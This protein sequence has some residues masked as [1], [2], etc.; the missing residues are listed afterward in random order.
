MDRNRAALR[1]AMWRGLM[2]TPLLFLGVFFFYPLAAILF[3]SLL[4]DGTLDLSGFLRVAQSAYYRDTLWFTTWQAA[5]STSLTLGLALPAAYVF[6]RYT[7][8]GRSFLL[9]L[10]TLAFVLPTVVV[11]AGFSALVGPRGLVN[12]FLMRVFSLSAPPIQLQHT[13]TLI[14]IA[15]VFY[16]FAV[17]LRIVTAYW[18]NQ[19]AQF[20]EAARVLGCHGW[21]LW[22]EIRLP[23]ARPAVLASTILVYIFTFT[24]FGVVLILGGPRFAT[25]EV[26]IYRQTVQLFNLPVAAALSLVQIVFMFALMLVY[27][28]FQS[29]AAGQLQAAAQMMSRPRT[30]REHGLV[31]CIGL[32]VG[33]LLLLPLAAL[34]ARSV[35]VNGQLSFAYYTG[36]GENPRGSVLFVAPFTAVVN[37]LQFAFATTLVSLL[38]GLL[39]AYLLKYAPARMARWLDPLFILPLAASPVTLGFGFVVAFNEPPLALRSTWAM[40]VIAHTLVAIPFVVRSVLPALRRVPSS[41]RDSAAT[42]GASPLAV[43]RWIDLP[44]VGRSLVVAAT[45]AFTV[46]AGE[47]GASLFVA[48]PDSPTLP[49]AIYRLLGQP[50]AI[51]YGQALALSVI[52][53]IVC[54]VCFALIERLRTGALEEF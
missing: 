25:V 8:P 4:A 2:L 7:F 12:D 34:V 15:H 9:S 50:G 49:I 52:L 32:I 30:L 3:V 6:A 29:Q 41:M 43:A 19:S 46:S 47:F 28:R 11:A 10:A 16:N 22:Y 48:R 51:N 14:L 31:A 53:M 5:L 18:A 40:V 39:S 38:L 24:S 37:S 36:L 33:A 35:L 20:E 21:R 17:I 27:A 54:A 13:L 45:F 23:L 1:L 44:V 42:L 26:E